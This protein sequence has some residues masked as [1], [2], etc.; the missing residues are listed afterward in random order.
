MFRTPP[1][2]RRILVL[3]ATSLIG[4]KLLE[5][6][7]PADITLVALSRRPA[8]RAYACAEW[9]VCDLH[10][11][12]LALRLGRLDAVLSLSPIWLLP[13]ILPALLSTDPSRLVAFSSTS[14]LTKAGSPVAAE[15]EVSARLAAGEEAVVRTC[16][17]A[18]V[19]WT[20]LRPTL[21]YS[22]GEDGNISRLAALIDRFGV[23][24]LA[25]RGDGLRQPVHAADL[26]EAAWRALDAPEAAGRFYAL[27]GGETLSYRDMA[28]RIF[29]ALG[30]RPRLITLPPWLWRL[31]LR[32]ASPWLPGATVAMGGRMG[33][34][35]S[36]DAAPAMRDFGYAP[37]P[38]TPTFSK[39]R[40]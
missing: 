19:G 21:I 16:T 31:S 39:G 35:L 37:R 3:G 8:P 33:T 6:P 26:A 12:G 2:P 28:A 20:I 30:R 32:L 5:A 24:P 10:D 34:D 38:F 4:R 9:I 13:A 40:R 17:A 23:L 29:D 27:P 15:R 25:G 7:L 22:E 1:M 14:R 36:F 11:H 18:G